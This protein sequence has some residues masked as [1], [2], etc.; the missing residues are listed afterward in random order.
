MSQE[1]ITAAARSLGS[2]TTLRGGPRTV[3][4]TAKILR[5]A[6]RYEPRWMRQTVGEE[7]KIVRAPRLFRPNAKER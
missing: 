4:L 7:P 3:P 5:P 1:H 6:A 2:G